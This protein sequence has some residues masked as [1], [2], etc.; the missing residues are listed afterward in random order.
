MDR[1]IRAGFAGIPVGFRTPWSWSPKE[2][3]GRRRPSIPAE[4]HWIPWLSC[5]DPLRRNGFAGIGPDSRPYVL[6]PPSEA[7]DV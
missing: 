2:R 6:A 3:S 5:W 4:S 7:P 1:R